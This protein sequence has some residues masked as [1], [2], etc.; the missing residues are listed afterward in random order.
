MDECNP[1]QSGRYLASASKDGKAIIWE[2]LALTELK[3]R[4]V[5]EP[6]DAA[7]AAVGAPEGTLLTVPLEH[8]CW[9]PDDA[10]LLT[11]G[12]NQAGGVLRTSTRPTLNL[13]FLLRGSV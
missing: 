5:L 6:S 2:V 1:L 7:A 4:H 11:C 13:L 9:S 8:V 3:V 10:H 12:D